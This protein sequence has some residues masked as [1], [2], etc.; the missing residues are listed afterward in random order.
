VEVNKANLQHKET[1]EIW[2]IKG[3]AGLKIWTATKDRRTFTVGAIP[4]YDLSFIPSI[5]WQFFFRNCIFNLI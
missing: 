2:G 3:R 1:I 5:N 4:R